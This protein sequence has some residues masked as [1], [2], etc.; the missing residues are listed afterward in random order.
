M[1]SNKF[2]TSYSKVEKG[3]LSLASARSLGEGTE[4]SIAE[5]ATLEMDF[6]G[7]LKVGKLTL[8]GVVQPAGVYSAATAAKFIKGTGVLRSGQ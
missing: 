7:E 8:G 3:T 5:G 2:V 6:Q 1:P 4:V